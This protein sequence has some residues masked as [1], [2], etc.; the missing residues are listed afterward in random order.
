MKILL[1]ISILFINLTN[2]QIAAQLQLQQQQQLQNIN[3]I[4]CKSAPE[5][6]A[7]FYTLNCTLINNNK[8][9]DQLLL[10][11]QQSQHF[12]AK[13]SIE[14]TT[15]TDGGFKVGLTPEWKTP[16]DEIQLNYD[17]IKNFIWK[18]SRISYIGEYTFKELTYLEKIDLSSNRIYEINVNA[19]KNF[20]SDVHELDLSSN[21]FDSIPT[22]LFK[23]KTLQALEVFKFNDN[24]IHRLN[25]RTFESMTKLN[26][27]ELNNC[28]IK[29]IDVNAFY[30]LNV[31]EHLS[32]NGNHL[33]T[34]NEATFKDLRLS[35]LFLNE[36]LFICDCNLRWVLS[37]LKTL[38]MYRQTVLLATS[39]GLK[40]AEPNSLK[41]KQ[42][43][44]DINP[45][46]FMCDVQLQGYPEF[47]KTDLMVDYGDEIVLTCEIYADPEPLIYWMYGNKRLEMMLSSDH[48]KYQIVE[49]NRH[50][51]SLKTNKT[52]ELRIKNLQ[53]GDIGTYTCIGEIS[54]TTN[55]KQ[56]QF[57][58]KNLL[59]QTKFNNM[60]HNK[61]LSNMAL[62]I[63]LSVFV[64]I[65]MLICTICIVYFCVKCKRLRRK[66]EEE[67]EENNENLVNNLFN[68]DEFDSKLPNCIRYAQ[69][70]NSL[71][72][73]RD[74]NKYGTI[75][76]ALLNNSSSTIVQPMN[77]NIYQHNPMFQHQ[78]RYQIL[79][80]HHNQQQQQH[81]QQQQESN[82]Y[83]DDLRMPYDEVHYIP[84][85][86]E[87]L[88]MQQHQQAA[89]DYHDCMMYDSVVPHQ[90]KLL[91]PIY[92]TLS[93]KCNNSGNSG[94]Y[95]QI[96]LQNQ[97]SMTLLSSSSSS[98][99]AAVAATRVRNSNLLLQQQSVPLKPKRTFEYSQPMMLDN[100]QKQ[101]SSTTLDDEDLDLNDLKDF[102]DVT[103]DNL[104]KPLEK[105]NQKPKLQVVDN[106][107]NNNKNLQLLP[108]LI[109]TTTHN[110]NKLYEE[111]EI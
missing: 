61:Y 7:T 15:S 100:Q 90:N 55:R 37:Y 22:Y 71:I 34:L 56:L 102:E 65:V 104:R 64:V 75:T 74:E 9:D 72:N 93:T 50:K 51:S 84:T 53:V 18:S 99:A 96:P 57:N 16:W 83:Y 86:D 13:T 41:S 36:N 70:S 42:N 14:V 3:R 24:K 110:D 103:F 69:K 87:Q 80:D 35:H 97:Q 23:I 59:K 101:N 67:C 88:R 98:T 17:I 108:K 8:L 94:Y 40:C 73:N 92:G 11:Q 39:I 49:Q 4:E 62:F 111:T 6:N 105:V 25:N 52:S 58:L 63:I 21:L 44:L 5:R 27:L 30:G 1:L 10:H 107:E 33:K 43:L 81:Q 46:S 76:E 47:N 48:E 78:Q 2:Q 20:E 28:F 77:A 106:S 32:L 12:V 85:I 82:C 66:H 95:S 91:T 29:E 68:N 89:L 19:F 109:E 38:D 54:G 79:I 31:L 26:Y 60:F 45:D